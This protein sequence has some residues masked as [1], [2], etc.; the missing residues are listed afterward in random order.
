MYVRVFRCTRLYMSIVEH[1]FR[2]LLL[3]M[4]EN[5]CVTRRLCAVQTSRLASSAA[6][7][8]DDVAVA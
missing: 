8:D 5:D 4:S 7:E 1:D 6:A 3:E 2:C